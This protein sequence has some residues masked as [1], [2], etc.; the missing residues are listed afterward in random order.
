MQLTA[1]HE[2]F[3]HGNADLER[4]E[5][6]REQQRSAA[7]LERSIEML[8]PADL[9]ALQ[10]PVDGCEPADPHLH[11]RHADGDEVLVDQAATVRGVEIAE[12]ELDVAR[13]DASL[14]RLQALQQRPERSTDASLPRAR[15]LRGAVH[16]P[17]QR[18]GWPI[19][20][21]PK[22]PQRQIVRISSRAP[23]PL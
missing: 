23:C 6:S 22:G 15:Q 7:T 18:P 20:R 11:E 13:R 1:R 4:R 16:E 14:A 2:H 21:S 8:A 9:Y 12:T 5:V 17:E 19:A 10:Q 3:E